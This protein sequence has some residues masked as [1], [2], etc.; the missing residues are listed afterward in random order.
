[1]TTIPTEQFTGD[2]SVGRSV[3]IGGKATIRGNI[4]A[5]HNLK[6]EGW[7]DA[8]NVRGAN[9]G[10][11][12]TLD[13][14]KAAYPTP[15]PGWWAL[16]GTTLPADLYVVEGNEWVSTGEKAGEVTVDNTYYEEEVEKLEDSIAALEES[17]A[18]KTDLEATNG[19]VTD[20]TAK[21]NDI[22]T[23]LTAKIDAV[24]NNLADNY[25]LSAE[26]V[27]RLRGTSDHTNAYYD[28][29]IQLGDFDSLAGAT[30]ALDKLD[31]TKVKYG[32][33]FR[34]CVNGMNFSGRNY[35]INFASARIV[36]VLQGPVTVVDGALGKI[37]T[38]YTNAWRILG[39]GVWS[40]WTTDLA[41]IELAITSAANAQTTADDALTK[42]TALTAQKGAAGGLA[43]LDDN[44]I[45][46]A[47]HLPAAFDDVVEYSG[48]VCSKKLIADIESGKVSTDDGCAVY[49]STY[50]KTFVL[51]VKDTSVGSG[52]TSGCGC[53]VCDC[54]E[55][56]V[57]YR[58]WADERLW[59]TAAG[60]PERGKAYV[61]TKEDSIWRWNGTDLVMIGSSAMYLQAVTEMAEK[62]FAASEAATAAV[63]DLTARVA[64]LE[65]L[66][67]LK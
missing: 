31:Y 36:Q 43:P 22:N 9:K 67:T 45:V 19:N 3:T 47:K 8:K 46:P 13:A 20:L 15:Q 57:Y 37:T 23:N 48:D 29:F 39:S 33:E 65:Y 18:E 7:L 59:N 51:G 60:V 35:A 44:G 49:Y 32:G 42:V 10:L 28:P 38:T 24:D 55:G 26:V 12:Q 16:V 30:D 56:Y 4:T 1:M 64:Q 17:K 14:L 61:N 40:K 50:A 58:H 6:V 54:D 53:D 11:H 41:R 66:L 25:M 5:G 52:D 63:A 27:K 62:A 2:V 34:F 21:V